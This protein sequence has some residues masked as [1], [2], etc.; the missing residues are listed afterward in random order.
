MVL[1]LKTIHDVA[2]INRVIVSTYQSVSG[3]GK[4][5]MDELFEQTKDIYVN[6]NIK[7]IK[8]FIQ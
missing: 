7:K 6:K 5:A 8:F 1:A 4:A 3:A 2:L